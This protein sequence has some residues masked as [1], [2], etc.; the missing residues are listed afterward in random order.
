MFT[1]IITDIGIVDDIIPLEKGLKLKIRTIYD[2]SSIE[3]GSSIACNGIC[4]TVIEK[5]H[6]AIFLEAWAEALSLTTINEWQKGDEINL[7]KSLRIG[8]EIGGHL[9]S[10]HVDAKAQIIDKEK[11]GGSIRFFIKSP[12]ELKIFIAQKGSIAL[13]GTSLTVNSV[14]DNIFDVLI[15]N[16]T[17]NVTN[18]KKKKVGDILNM[19]IDQLSRYC[20]RYAQIQQKDVSYER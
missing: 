17:L 15:I 9:I 18:W 16:H 8:D 6:S 7:E 13:D 2:I 20:V 10:G 11:I 1:G 12:D 14:N 4:L 3:I 5:A 19:E